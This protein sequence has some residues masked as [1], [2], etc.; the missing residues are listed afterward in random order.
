[1]GSTIRTLAKRRVNGYTRRF[2]QGVELRLIREIPR[3]EDYSDSDYN[4]YLKACEAMDIARKKTYIEH[5][6]LNKISPLIQAYGKSILEEEMGKIGG[7]IGIRKMPREAMLR[8]ASNAGKIG[9]KKMS[10]EAKV[11]G[12]LNQPREAKVR[13]GLTQGLKHRENGTG[14]FSLTPE[15]RKQASSKGGR[16]AVESGHLAKVRTVEHQREAGRK[17]G[18]KSVE[19]GHLARIRAPLDHTS[20]H[21]RRAGCIGGRIGGPVSIRKMPREAKVRGGQISGCR[22]WNVNRGKPCTCGQHRNYS[23]MV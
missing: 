11:R 22:R 20:E 5:G 12:A 9:I 14:I 1:V 19:S 4:F 3:P 21:Q 23:I 15:E 17:G 18:R 16:K 7:R 2:G 8:G 13:G 10:R 6:G